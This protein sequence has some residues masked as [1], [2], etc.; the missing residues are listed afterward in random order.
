MKRLAY[1]VSHP[2]QYQAPLLRLLAAEPDLEIKV[3]FYSDFSVKGYLDPGFQ[4]LV[5]W[6]V[7]LTQGYD[8]HFLQTWGA[9]QPTDTWRQAIALDIYAQLKQGQFDAVWVHGWS[10]ICSLQAILAANRLDLPV[11]MRGESNGLNSRQGWKS[12]LKAQ[13]FKWLLPRIAKFLYI[14]T[15]NRQFYQT[16]GITSDRLYPV[17][18]AVDNDFFFSLSQQAQTHRNQLRQSLNL[19]PNRPIILYAAK[20]VDWKRPQDLIAAHRL[21]PEH[22]KPYL[23][24]V[25]DGE[26]RT[27]LETLTSGDDSI[28]FL[29][30]RNQSQM[31]AIYDLCDL[32]V[33][34]SSFEPW[35]LAINEVMNAG[36]AVVV[37]DAVGC[38][39]DLV[40]DQENGKIFA[41]GNIEQLQASL[42]WAIANSAN[43]GAQSHG[44]IRNWSF[45]TDIEGIRASLA[46]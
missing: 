35:G 20:L 45:R 8:H 24:F 30:F 1:F 32:F 27:A 12:L 18:Y 2:I 46:L 14:G 17:P 6:D 13:F 7:P 40:K 28:R 9:K 39:P 36:K 23:L 26:M 15:L 38:A 19:Q 34:P 25:G 29:G 11:L 33:L 22:P 43:A 5:E 10:Q 31:P 4:Q 16:L 37:S 42:A 3:F 21:L 41:T 44:I